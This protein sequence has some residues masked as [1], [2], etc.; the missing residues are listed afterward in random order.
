MKKPYRIESQRAV[1][2][3]EEMAADGNPTVRTVLPNHLWGT[4]DH[5][6]FNEARRIAAICN[7]RKP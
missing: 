3:L 7:L 5:G 2:Q 4:R 1:R 6:N